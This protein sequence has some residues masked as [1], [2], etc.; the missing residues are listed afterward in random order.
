[1]LEWKL[2]GK[3]AKNLELIRVFDRNTSHPLIRK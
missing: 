3:L 1:M 2:N